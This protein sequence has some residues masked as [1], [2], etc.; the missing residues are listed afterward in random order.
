MQ[1][2]HL[3]WQIKMFRRSIKKQQKLRALLELLGKTTGKKCL[4]VT[5]GDNNGA[6]NWYI[7]EH[8]GEW[9]WADVS[10][11]NN[12]QIA[13]LLGEPVH[14]YREDAFQVPDG[15][16]DRVVSIDVLE[17]LQQDQSFLKEVKRV[18]K[19][20]GRA[21]VTVPNG[22]P[23]LLANQIKWKL[24]MTPEVYGHT[25]AGYTIAELSD[26]IRTAGLT[27]Q[28]TG[29]Y[30]RFVTEMIELVINFGYVRVLSKKR[31]GAQPGHIAPVSSGELKT[32]GMA[33][34][35]YSL[36]FPFAWVISLLD[37]L[38][39]AKTDNAVIVTALKQD[40]A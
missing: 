10:G 33:Y 28:K 8:G 21:V 14:A 36:L 29:G 4:L 25:R 26:S 16:F 38:F 20:N 19:S 32:H 1:S 22:D 17:H 3:P 18:L 27:P 34:K 23:K 2:N 7:R 24:G 31:G 15:Q 11:E 40:G 35:I 30:S 9:T 12:D 39:P 6:L 37:N 5:C 13:Q